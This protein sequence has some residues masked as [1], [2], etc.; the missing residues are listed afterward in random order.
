MNHSLFIIISIILFI[1]F[2]LLWFKYSVPLIYKPTFEKI[3]NKSLNLK[4]IPGL[5]A[6]S[7]LGIAAYYFAVLNSYSYNDVILNASLLGFVIYGVYNGTN[8]ATFDDWNFNIFFYDTLWGTFNIT[9]VSLIIWNIKN[10]LFT[11]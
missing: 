3:Q 11:N 6:W 2:D 4:I 5:F 7:L 1:T 10:Y 8:F 9:F